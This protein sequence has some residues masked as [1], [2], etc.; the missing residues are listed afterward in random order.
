LSLNPDRV[1]ADSALPFTGQLTQHYA[2]S[3]R[4]AGGLKLRLT[5]AP[6]SASAGGAS[7]EI[8][9]VTVG[10][11]NLADEPARF[12]LSLDGVADGPYVLTGGIA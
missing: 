12:D 8:G 10:A 3:Y 2:A 7:R 9:A 5:L 11:G 1:V 4:P 6:E